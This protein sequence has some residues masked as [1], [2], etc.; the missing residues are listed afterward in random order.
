[1]TIAII[2]AMGKELDLLLPYLENQCK[3]ILDGLEYYEGT[4]HGHKTVMMQCG[5]GKV[6]S[7]IRTYR[8]I[9]E[10]KPD[11]VINSGVAGGASKEM[12]P[13][14]IFIAE[15]VSYHDVWCGPGTK[16]GAADGFEQFLMTCDKIIQIAIN[17]IGNA[18]YGLICSGDKFI[19]SKKEIEDIR[20]EF[21]EVKAVDM[22]SASIGQVCEMTNIPFNIIRV[23]SDNPED[24]DNSAQYNSFWD[25]APKATFKAILTIISHIK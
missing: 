14:T 19:S 17:N 2:A 15:K 25:E 11:L 5:I 20:K 1:M 16:Y 8:L 10:F 12:K 7:A 24:G 22:E 23:I 21:P 13:L 4:L 9:K 6:N 3:V 18:V